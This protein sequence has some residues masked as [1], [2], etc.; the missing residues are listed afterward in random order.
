MFDLKGYEASLLEGAWMTLQVSLLSVVLAMALGMIGA[1]SKLSR[2][3]MA[4]RLATLYT[5][6]VR[7]IPD[8]ILMMLLFFGGQVFVNFLCTQINEYL[9]D[10]VLQGNAQH[11]WTAYVPEY[12]DISPF[13]AGVLTIGFIFG[14]YMTETFRGAILA[15]DRGQLEAAA[16]YG[17]TPWQVFRRVLFP[18][19]VRTGSRNDPAAVHLLHGCCLD[20]P[21]FYCI[22]DHPAQ[23]GRTSLF[24]SDEVSH[25]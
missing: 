16:A 3:R 1:V 20:L 7:G 18:Q 9:N 8:L 24:D 13:I 5:T 4:K 10:W 6:V 25:V 19:M 2:Y 22:F 21:S 14:A 11:E 12:V 17:M 23:M 15:V